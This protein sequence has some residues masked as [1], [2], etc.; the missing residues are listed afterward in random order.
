MH[1]LR[2]FLFF[3]SP[4]FGFLFFSAASVVGG[5]YSLVVVVIYIFSS[6]ISPCGKVDN[7]SESMHRHPLRTFSP[8]GNFRDGCG[9]MVEH[10]I[11]SHTSSEKSSFVDFISVGEWCYKRETLGPARPQTPRQGI[12][13]LHLSRRFSP[14]GKKDKFRL[15]RWDD[16]KLEGFWP[17]KAREHPRGK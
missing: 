9:Y 4:C 17:K 10:P 13:P 3:D 2:P 12:H 11:F 7:F 8:C 1:I 16:E 5:R 15:P 6:S 14:L